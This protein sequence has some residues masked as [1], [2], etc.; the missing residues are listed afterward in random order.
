MRDVAVAAQV[1]LKTVSRVVN[2]HPSVAPEIVSRVQDA[3]RSIDYL[4]NMAAVSL[5]RADRRTLTIGLVLEDVSNPFASALH[6]AVVDVAIRRGTLVF[7]GSTDEDP[8]RE[9]ELLAAFAS[10]QVDGLIL[11]PAWSDGVGSSPDPM[12]PGT[13]I[14]YADRPGP[15][16]DSDSVMAD[17]RVGART[18]VRHLASRGHRRI[19]FLG[20]ARS[21]WTARERHAGYVEGLAGQGLG[22]DPGLVRQDFPTIEAAEGAALDL[23][24]SPH[25]P[26][27]LFSG[28]NLITLG[29]IRALRQRGL[30]SRVALIGFDDIDLADMLEP[31]V[32]VIAQD[33]RVLG[34]TAANLLFERLADEARE[35][36]RV[37]VPTRLIARGSGEIPAR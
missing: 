18:A 4:P 16:P 13:P 6:R 15:W 34:R 23:L 37:V 19:A 31:A 10:H 1:S 29:A 22:Y 5:R 30:Q 9:R 21:I 36:R 2:G 14:V 26:T 28:Q 11:V 32:S 27:A 25:P 24:A 8:E 20:D 35:P 12:R 33:P 7:A 3:I 17:N